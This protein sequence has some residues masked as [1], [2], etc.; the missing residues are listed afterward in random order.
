SLGA[1]LRAPRWAIAY[2]YSP[3]E[4]TTKLLNIEIGVGRT[5]RVTPYAVMNPVFVFGSTPSMATSHNQSEAMR[6]PVLV[7]DTVMIRKAA[8]RIPAVLGP[9]LDKRGGSEVE[10]TFPEDC[11]SCG[12]KLAPQKEGDADWRC[13]NTRTCPAQL[14][15][16][17]EY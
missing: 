10:W 7:A 14:S 9:V 5:G 4:V 6:N 2:K 1:T 11:P 16:R 13:P 8:E 17:L 12:T 3:E 15:A